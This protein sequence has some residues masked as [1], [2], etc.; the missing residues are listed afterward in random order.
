MRGTAQ[1][2]L[3]SREAERISFHLETGFWGEDRPVQPPEETRGRVGLLDQLGRE[4]C[5]PGEFVFGRFNAI[6]DDCLTPPSVGN[7]SAGLQRL[8]DRR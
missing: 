6:V 2:C 5:V 8:I 1:A 3:V 7:S 4:L